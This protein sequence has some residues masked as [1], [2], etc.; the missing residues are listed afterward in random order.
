MRTILDTSVLIAHS[1]G[2]I[3]GEITISCAS[4]AELNFG[5]LVARTPE[6]RATRLTRLNEIIRR[7]EPL[8]MDNAVAVSYAVLAAATVKSGRQPRARAMHL[9][10]AATAHATGARLATVNVADVNHLSDLIEII[11]PPQPST[12]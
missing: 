12:Q 5:V 4:I 10:I 3:P 2:S 1:F 6:A 8:P 9:I 7:F 11:G